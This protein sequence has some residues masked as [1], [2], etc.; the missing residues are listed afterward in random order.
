MRRR[1]LSLPFLIAG[2]ALTLAWTGAAVA[3]DPLFLVDDQT[4]VR[5]IRFTFAERQTFEPDLLREQ[6][7][8]TDQ[9]GLLFFGPGTRSTLDGIPVLGWLIPGLG[10]H[11][12]LPIEMQKDVVRLRRFYNR[13]G[14]LQP[15]IDWLTDLDTTRNTIKV[16][17]TID[18][19][20]PLLL[21]NLAF[22]DTT[23]RPA[24][25]QLPA[26]LHPAWNAFRDRIA[27]QQG[28]RLDD[29]RLLQ[30]EDATLS[31]VRDQGYAFARVEAESDVDSLANRA[32]VTIRLAAGP[33]GRVSEIQVEGSDSVSPNVVRRE[34]PFREGDRFS[35]SE[36]VEGQREV[37]GLNLFQIALADVPEGQPEDSSVVVR[38]RV[39]EG[40]ARIVSGSVG[41]LSEAGATTQAQW[42]HRNFFGGA[43][44]F[45]A[46]AVANTGA[47]AIV[48]EPQRLYRASVLLRQPYF[49]NRRLALLGSPFA[50]F[51]DDD[52]NE[53][54]TYGGTATLLYEVEPLKTASLQ[55]GIELRDVQEFRTASTANLDLA[56]LLDFARQDSLQDVLAGRVDRSTLAVAGSYG[57]LDD[58]LDPRRGYILRPTAEVALP[59][60]ITSV[61]YG[62]L[63]A[64]A[65]GFFPLTESIGLYGRVNGGR[66]FAFGTSVPGSGA[67]DALTEFVRLRN[68][69]F[70]GGGTG[71]VR[72]WGIGLLG[73]KVPDVE[74]RITEATLT[75]PADTTL[76][77]SRYVGIGGLSKVTATAEVR[78]P[79]PGF[80]PNF[81]TFVFL[82]AGRVW[83]SDERFLTD[84]EPDPRFD[85]L[86]IN[87]D[88]FFYAAGAG[89]AFATP[90][91]AI[92][93]SVGY[94]LNPDYFD[95][96][97]PQDVLNALQN[98]EPLADVPTNEL[99]IFGLFTIP[100]SNRIHLHF[101]IG[102]TF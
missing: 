24:V 78:L 19:G 98:G 32:D 47:G 20:P 51:R 76:R 27:L 33:R 37:F 80:G 42:T 46:S 55:Y 4:Q 88:R 41:Y 87:P 61:E 29:F 13:N 7:A 86:D 44:T 28:E 96:R 48:S 70:L 67:D 40:E 31:W 59:L 91:G 3:Q 62:R 54:T 57:A 100:E 64:T 43:R 25:E 58:D 1:P 26:S 79:F 10:V 11:P 84:E 83:T 21:D 77:A 22:Q 14:F 8:L 63:G 9:P 99:P 2:F 34:L 74:Q 38:L 35:F 89:M 81:G 50:E 82:D 23:G 72:G 53:S 30:L 18:E 73:P 56:T 39:R 49:L 71:D 75:T 65:T 92:R 85:G 94:K 66:L 101:S 6:I 52:R 90:V 36:L 68:V 12:F 17:F 93:F 97:S 69:V 16:L 60:P 102:Q 15:E 5:S 95:L 45:T